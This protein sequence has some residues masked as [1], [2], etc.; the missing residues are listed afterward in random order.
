[1][2]GRVWRRERW[3]YKLAQVCHRWRNLILGSTSYLGL[4]LVCTHGTP[5]ADM[6]AHSP[7]LPLVIDYADNDR[8]VTTEEEEIIL[9]LAQRDRVRRIRF[10]MPVRNLKKII[11]T[12]NGE[13]PVLEYLIM[14]PLEKNT[15]M[16]PETL[17]APH[18][19]H[20][21]LIGF[22]LPIRS[23]LLTTAV[24]LVT[25]ALGGGHTHTDFH[26]N[27]L[28]QCMPFMPRLEV[29]LIFF[30]FPVSGPES[31]PDMEGQLMHMPIT[32]HITLPNLRRFEFRGVSAYMEAV[33][34]RI[35]T[36][37]LERLDVLFFNQLTVSVPHLVQ[38]I[39]TTENL[40]FGSA[41]FKF[42]NNMVRVE[43]YPLEDATIYALSIKVRCRH[44]DWHEP[45]AAQIFNSLSQMFFTVE[46]LTLEY[47]V[48]SQT[49]GEVDRTEWRNLLRSFSNIKTLRFDDGLV[50]G[51][52][53]CLR[54]DDGEHPLELLP[55][56]QVLGYSG[57]SDTGDA[58]T[59][60][61]DAR[62]N[63]G[64]TV[65]LVHL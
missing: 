24:G 11:M 40:K 32:M 46:H 56:L 65:T 10:R 57:S 17:Q 22:V 21:L 4:C 34:R 55:E 31:A 6:L 48:H 49:S 30:T 52:S 38:F 15:V 42:S 28:L 19:H 36:P 16:I 61:I 12:I 13:Y 26:P 60:F 3:W 63:A 29:L 23:R 18:L 45:P 58:F 9:A 8:D 7:P 14:M 64:N 53:R 27:V 62:Q 43:V 37:R 59:P 44:L 39:K 41:K 50:K 47:E 33:L 5:V 35:T 51:L 2:G 1:M 54:L 25:F 20:L